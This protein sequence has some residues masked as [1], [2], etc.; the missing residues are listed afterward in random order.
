MTRAEP[1]LLQLI[2]RHLPRCPGYYRSEIFARLA[3]RPIHKGLEARAIEEMAR[4][5]IR[6]QLTDYD[7]LWSE[8]GLE[9]EEARIAV[10]P[11]V[12]EWFQSW[13]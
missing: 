11:E 6:H 7:L 5:V 13:R 12:E 2:R 3:E 10:E 1:P 8:H 9:P 4:A